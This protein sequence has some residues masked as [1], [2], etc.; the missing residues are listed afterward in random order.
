[1]C[2][3]MMCSVSDPPESFDSEAPTLPVPADVPP[4]TALWAQLEA[5]RAK[6]Q[7]E[8]TLPAELNVDEILSWSLTDAE[9]R[10]WDE[11]PEFRKQHPVTFDAMG[12]TS[13][14]LLP[15]DNA[16]VS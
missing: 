16:D 4:R 12:P 9:K 7:Q 14:E 2:I 1:M 15:E 10:V 8:G 6:A 11:L 13:M 5:L 3:E